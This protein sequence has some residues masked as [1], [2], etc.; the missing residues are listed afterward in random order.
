M[1][2]YINYLLVIMLCSGCS[3][4]RSLPKD[5]HIYVK[6]EVKIIKPGKK[7][8]TKSLKA[9]YNTL[10]KQPK[11]NKKFLG[12]RLK[13]QRYNLFYKTN[14][15]RIEKG[16]KKLIGEPPV[17]YNEQITTQMKKLME[18]KAF[19]EGFLNV[20]VS[21]KVKKRRRK[22]KV[23][24]TVE[25]GSSFEIN[26]I[27]NGVG[28]SLIRMN[29][30]QI[31]DASLLKTGEPYS[32]QKLKLERSRIATTLRGKGFYFFRDDYFKFL[33]DT[34]GRENKMHI[35][36]TLK[37]AIDSSHLKPKFIHNIY[38]Y[39]D[40]NFKQNANLQTDTIDYEGLKIIFRKELIHPSVLRDAITL[41]Q[42]EL[43]SSKNHQSSLE[44]L[45][46]LRYHQFMDI[47][48]QQSEI[49]DSLLDVYVQLTPRKRETIEGAL[50][51]S[52]NSGLYAGPEVSL[53]YR[54]RNLFKGAEQLRVSTL[55]NFS[56]PLEDDLASLQ[57]RGLSLELSKPGLIVPF[58]KK[59]W[60][61]NLIGKSKI[62]LN[63]TSEKIRLPLNGLEDFLEDG[64]Y[65]ELADRL[66]IDSTFSPF[67]A[68]DKIELNIAYQ[69][70][71]RIDIQ[72][73][74]TPI[75]FIIQNSRYEV[76]ELRSLLL[77]I[78][79]LDGSSDDV[80]LNLEN[81]LILKPNYAF[82]YDSRLRRLK[83]HNYYYRGKVAVSGNRLL[84]DNPLIPSELVE[85]QF[86]QLENDI[87][88]YR[89]LSSRHTIA[90]RF[91]VKVSIPFK[92][93]VILP[94]FDLYNV[95][96]P[97]SI[98]AFRPR[99]VGPGSVEPSEE[100]FFF[101]GT[102]DLL[103]ES[104]LEWRP[105]INNFLELGFFIDAGNVWLF[106]G[107]TNE[108]ELATFK[109]SGFYNQLAI[110][111]GFGLRFNFNFLI[112]RL[113]LATPL[114]KPWFPEGE[115]WIGNQIRLGSASWIRNNVNFNLGFGYS[116]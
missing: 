31:Q 55:G 64:G 25:L 20:V 49:A 32:L 42:G 4:K 113:D 2:K 93:E 5:S 33:A 67:I 43:Y 10:I 79:Q 24:Y 17:I 8:N 105:K 51:F 98:R 37:E 91:A 61:E 41:K 62:S 83:R 21:S 77:E 13:L 56:F 7:T 19:N 63:Y 59:R 90:T 27:V 106:K 99:A 66:N 94:F 81:M 65:L 30:N 107:G 84:S 101:T 35:E 80:Q 29:V 110:G 38:V 1:N 50:G 72:H 9:T 11:P 87:R 26:N 103:L 74:F 111:T 78:I 3:L 115:R 75:S 109:F 97:N 96:G 60:T 85:S 48:F 23:K 82:L 14:K 16:R 12:M 95:G 47:Q 70:R 58:R 89:R 73:E 22:A 114:T 36:L 92:N 102:G 53:T 15:K 112:L 116:F 71:K 6:S 18:N 69:W 52:I 76:D 88:Y 45:S 57:E 34:I 28:D 54:N 46:F 40:L 108:D 39:P 86:F 100:V 104:N 68:L 44:R